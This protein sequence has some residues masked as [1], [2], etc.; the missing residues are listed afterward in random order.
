M[1]INEI[2]LKGEI[3]VR[4][5]NTC[6][7][8]EIETIAELKEF[9]NTC[10]SFKLFRNCG[11]KTDSELVN[12]CLKYFDLESQQINTTDIYSNQNISNLLS[13]FDEKKLIIIDNFI[14]AK[15]IDLSVRSSNALKRSGHSLLKIWTNQ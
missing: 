6:T 10:G 13:D 2:F 9:F 15:F 14:K 12:I 8:N 7:D 11:R 4:A 1:T 5:L 3:S